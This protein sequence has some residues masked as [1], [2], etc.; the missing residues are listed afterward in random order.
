MMQD[1][2]LHCCRGYGIWG[3]NLLVA[4]NL[5]GT[6]FRVATLLR[7]AFLDLFLY[8]TR[9]YWRVVNECLR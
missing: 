5:I 1:Y 3:A 6:R 9:L 8:K 7:C 2:V 4:A